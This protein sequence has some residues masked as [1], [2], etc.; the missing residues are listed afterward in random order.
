M[1][2]DWFRHFI[3]PLAYACTFKTL[4]GHIN[5]ITWVA[6]FDE[7]SFET[8]LRYSCCS[9]PDLPGFTQH[10]ALKTWLVP[11]SR[12]WSTPIVRGSQD[13]KSR[14]RTPRNMIITSSRCFGKVPAVF[15]LCCV[16]TEV[17]IPWGSRRYGW[18]FMSSCKDIFPS[19]LDS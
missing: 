3:M 9:I 7:C 14:N 1:H 2:F 13:W 4:F 16:E 19:S 5:V 10:L 6:I 17:R 8:L 15:L 18:V 11:S 12:N